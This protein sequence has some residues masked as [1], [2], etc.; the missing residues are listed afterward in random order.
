MGR[1]SE[2]TPEIAAALVEATSEG[3]SVQKAA[4]RCGI[5]P[6]TVYQWVRLHPD[7][8]KLYAQARKDAAY[9]LAEET[10]DIADDSSR[11]FELDEETGKYIFN[12]EHVQR[13]RLRWDARRWLASK[14]L[15]KVFGDKV[16]VEHSGSIATGQ[17]DA[18][19]VIDGL[20][21]LA[22]EQPIAALPLITL[23]E[24]ALTRLRSNPAI[25][26]ALEHQ[27]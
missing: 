16:E 24:D 22:N 9:V 6:V 3:L 5:A 4:K 12:G 2:Y 7:F 11:D 23:L 19:G 18:Q 13:A 1:P 25:R 17:L 8:A 27:P 21:S 10:I 15:P 14:Y 20:V 26:P